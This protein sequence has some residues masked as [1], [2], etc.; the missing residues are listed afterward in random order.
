MFDYSVITPTAAPEKEFYI[1]PLSDEDRY[2]DPGGAAGTYEY[3]RLDL[4]LEIL[5]GYQAMGHGRDSFDTEHY[6][7]SRQAPKGMLARA[8][9]RQDNEG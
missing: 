8:I 7:Y 2:A 3:A 5:N 4:M 1:I 9:P 6:H